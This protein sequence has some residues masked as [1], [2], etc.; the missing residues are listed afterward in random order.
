MQNSS[1]DNDLDVFLR[2]MQDVTPIEQDNTPAASKKAP[3]LA[4]QLKRQALEKTSRED[5]IPFST[6][7][8]HA[9]SPFDEICYKK[10]GVQNKVFKNLRLGK[11]P[12]DSTLHITV[13]DLDK[14]RVLVYDAITEGHKRG[15]RNLLI[16]HGLG[17]ND[18]PYPARLKSAINQWLPQMEAVIAC[19]SAL[20]GHGGLASTYVLLKKNEAEKH[21]NRELHR[22]K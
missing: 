20:K 19:H 11:Y 15:L 9:M 16:R 8:R 1:N 7:I 5:A 3:T 17:K 18:K 12:I 6:E 22:K 2:E 4:Q 10:E 14:A 13:S 21:A